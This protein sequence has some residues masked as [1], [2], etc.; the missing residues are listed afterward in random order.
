MRVGKFVSATV[1]GSVTKFADEQQQKIYK[2]SSHGVFIT[3][4]MHIMCFFVF[5]CF[6]FWSDFRGTT[7]HTDLFVKQFTG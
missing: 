4:Y 6:W 3:H 2:Y 1:L 5:R 7:T